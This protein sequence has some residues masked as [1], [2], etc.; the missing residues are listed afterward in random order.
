MASWPS[1]VMRR[2]LLLRVALVLIVVDP[3][4]HVFLGDDCRYLVHGLQRGLFA[5]IVIGDI[6]MFKACLKMH[7]I[8]A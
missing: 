8:A 3:E 5:P 7:N 1:L 2:Q 6:A 4:L